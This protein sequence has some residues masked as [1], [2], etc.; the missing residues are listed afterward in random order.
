MERRSVEGIVQAL[1]AAGIRYLVAGGL[2]VVAHGHVRFTADLDLVLD[3]A[4]DALRGAVTALQGLG[5]RPRAPV[6]F[7]EFADPG[8]RSAWAREKGMT[9][10]S[11]ASPL[12]PATEID[13]FL[14]PPFDFD[15]A[16]VRAARLEL[17]PG[18]V[19][20][21]VSLTDLLAMKRAVGR[22]QDLLD[23]AALESL[24]QA[25]PDSHDR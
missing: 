16:Y 18:V 2:A 17:A 21:F 10:F 4:P 7:D 8:R 6:S 9:V 25:E 19:A 24:R 1:E 14:E 15:A 5:Y 3:P 23:V 11:A 12:H 13:L 20:T 22:P